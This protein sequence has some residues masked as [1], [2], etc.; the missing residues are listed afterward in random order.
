M[1]HGDAPN[2]IGGDQ[3]RELSEKGSLEVK[4]TAK[5]I[6]NNYEIDHVI[7]SSAKRNRQTLEIMKQFV[8]VLSIDFSEEIY[9]NE[10]HIL[11]NLVSCLS[12]KNSTILMLGHN[13][14]L[15][16]FALKCDIDAYDAWHDEII[17]GM[18]T[19]E[20]IVVESKD[21]NDWKDFMTCS[22]KI[23][24]IFSFTICFLIQTSEIPGQ[25]SLSLPF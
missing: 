24:D 11:E 2:T 19:A 8:V 7:C 4:D 5:Y 25:Y 16:G 10:T 20:I 9:K 17:L 12:N 18:K 1:R 3:E 15:L 23:I 21:C 14:S 6:S 22:K 13:P